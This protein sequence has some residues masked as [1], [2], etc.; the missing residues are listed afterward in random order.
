MGRRTETTT[1]EQTRTV[2]FCDIC[3]RQTYR[4]LAC[5]GCGKDICEKM[6]CSVVLWNDP[7]TG[8][9]CG[10]SMELICH[11]CNKIVMRY[12]EEAERITREYDDKIGAIIDA[13]QKECRGE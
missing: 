13:F 12:S 10:D 6:A 7:L 11:E 4:L 8:D 1:V 9:D 5:Y 3:G 2:F